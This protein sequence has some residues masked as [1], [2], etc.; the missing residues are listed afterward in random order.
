M[1]GV[2][3]PDSPEALQSPQLLAWSARGTSLTLQLYKSPTLHGLALHQFLRRCPALQYLTVDGWP[4]P[5]AI[6]AAR[7][8]IALAAVPGVVVLGCHYCV[9]AG[10]FPAGLRR[11]RLVSIPERED[12]EVLFTRLQLLPDLQVVKLA[13]QGQQL[14]LR[15]DSLSGVRLPRLRSLHVDMDCRQGSMKLDLS[16]LAAP[17]AFAFI[18]KMTDWQEHACDRWVEPLQALQG[19]VL[20]SQDKLTLVVQPEHLCSAARALLDTLCL[21]GAAVTERKRD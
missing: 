1:K 12:V 15:K 7:F 6:D 17:R 3:L 2:S 14:L 20:Q 11:L 19:G 21:T 18:L 8:E 4:G 16:W 5:R 9:P 13:L 10:S